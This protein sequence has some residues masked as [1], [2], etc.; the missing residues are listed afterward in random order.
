[1]KK[2]RLETPLKKLFLFCIMLFFTGIVLFG[3]DVQF[4]RAVISSGGGNSSS[5]AVNLTRWRIGQINLVTL[6]SAENI[7]KQA[8]IPTS[9]LS[10]RSDEDWSATVYPNPVNTLL[11]VRFDMER[12]GEFT[13]ELYD[14]SGRKIIAENG[15]NILPGQVAEIDL[16]GLTPAL[17][18][19]KVIPSVEGTQKL[20]KITKQ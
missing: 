11:N 9:V 17:Y 20:F 15:L 14:V 13:L 12:R 4:P 8:I 10:E 6:P 18:L 1:M 7:P 5:N 19:L 2:K 16:T 3:Q